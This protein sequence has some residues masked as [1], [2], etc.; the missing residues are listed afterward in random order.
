VR[1]AGQHAI[2]PPNRVGFVETRVPSA[3]FA[4][5]MLDSLLRIA[6]RLDRLGM[7]LTRVGLVVVLVGHLSRP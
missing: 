4:I 2:I 7:T 3:E 6:A 5:E 1:R